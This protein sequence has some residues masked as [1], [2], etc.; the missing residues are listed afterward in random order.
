MKQQNH[1][2]NSKAVVAAIKFFAAIIVILA[3]AYSEIL[4]LGIISTLFP[5]GPLAVGAMLGAIT[6]GLSI[7]ALCIAKSHWFRP[8][9]QLVVAWSFTL[10]EIA[11]LVAND[12]LAYQLHTGAQ[13]CLQQGVNGCLQMGVQLDQFSQIWRTCCVAAPVV[14]LV[15]W[16]LLFYFSP[17]RSIAHKR[18]EMEDNQAKAQIDFETGMHA[19]VMEIRERAATMVRSRLEEKIETQM[20]FHLDKAAAKFIA[21]VASDLTGEE[22]SHADLMGGAKKQIAAPGPKVVEAD[23]PKQLAASRDHAV[24][25]HNVKSKVDDEKKNIEKKPIID[26]S[27]PKGVADTAPVNENTPNDD[28]EDIVEEDEAVYEIIDPE[29]KDPSEWTDQEW[30]MLYDRIDAFAFSDVWRMY[31]GDT[32]YPWEKPAPAKKKSTRAKKKTASQEE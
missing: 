9:M 7:L 4:F 6:T 25:P 12:I 27:L 19:H 29:E 28:A 10:I 3:V 22:V 17:E 2:A 15:G 14:S 1:S 20:D 8:G 16:V 5:A 18:M 11:I 31:K 23:P 32:P 30:R 13:V 26:F 21:R 24:D